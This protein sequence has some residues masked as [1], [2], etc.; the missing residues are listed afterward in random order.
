ME[1]KEVAQDI[2]LYFS[3]FDSFSS[4]DSVIGLNEW[5]LSVFLL[6]PIRLLPQHRRVIKGGDITPI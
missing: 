1:A 2:F 3:S 4:H 6:N 5:G